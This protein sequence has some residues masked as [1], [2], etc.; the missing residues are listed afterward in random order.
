MN[1]KE[2]LLIWATISF[3][4]LAI[5]IPW[6]FLYETIVFK[7]IGIFGILSSTA[8]TIVFTIKADKQAICYFFKS[9]LMLTDLI[10]HLANKIIN[11][12]WES[13]K[14][15]SINKI[16]LKLCITICVITAIPAI[17]IIL[18]TIILVVINLIWGWTKTVS[19]S[20]F[21]TKK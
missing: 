14:D 5:G 1:K 19:A 9:D 4:C 16:L 7:C 17:I 6:F 11:I 12:F 2:L 21:F 8:C 20:F 18:A 3:V 13:V 10:L 15:G